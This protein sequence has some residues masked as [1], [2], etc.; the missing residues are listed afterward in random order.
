MNLSATNDR[1]RF[2]KNVRFLSMADEIGFYLIFRERCC[3]NRFLSDYTLNLADGNCP[4]KSFRCG[5]LESLCGSF[6]FSKQ[7]SGIGE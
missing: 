1:A 4:V 5:L 3:V 6:S 7:D 2:C